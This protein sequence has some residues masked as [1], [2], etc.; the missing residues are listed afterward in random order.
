M[1]VIPQLDPIP[2]RRHVWLAPLVAAVILLVGGFATVRVG[3]WAGEAVRDEVTVVAAGVPVSLEIPTGSTARNIG[4]LLKDEGVIS[5][6][7]DFVNE[8]SVRELT[9]ALKAGP[10]EFTTGMSLDE[11]LDQLVEGPFSGEVF[12]VTVIEGLWINEVLDS[13][14]I[15]SAFTKDQ[16][17]EALLS[18]RISSG[19]M[20]EDVTGSKLSDW[21]GLLFPDTYEFFNAVSADTIVGTLVSTMEDRVAAVDWSRLDEIM[22]K[23]P[24]DLELRT[25]TQYEAIIIASLIEAEAKLDV[26]RPLISSVIYNRLELGQGLE[27]DAALVYARGER[28]LP[29]AADKE[30]DTLYNTYIHRGL[31]PTP[32][33]SVRRKSLEAAANPA[34]SA[35]FYYVLVSTDGSHGFSTTLEEHLAKVAQAR[36]DGVI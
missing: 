30:I 7:Q 11:V 22:V 17:V 21:E 33:G 14:A 32:I 3:R 28:G 19:L 16:L 23:D 24:G 6:A 26:D 34:D 2:P 27:I 31:P 9:S 10:Y 25:P 18:G 8:V 36:A 1:T 4:Q 29:T 35:F 15:Q 12:R 13:L 20:P 5:S